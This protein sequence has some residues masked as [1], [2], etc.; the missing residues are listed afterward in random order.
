MD[1]DRRLLSGNVGKGVQ[2]SRSRMTRNVVR[3]KRY[4]EAIE[5]KCPFNTGHYMCLMELDKM[6]AHAL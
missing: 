6:R 5:W 2:V 3:S 1:V 4:Q